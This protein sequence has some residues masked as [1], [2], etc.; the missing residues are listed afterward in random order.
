MRNSLLL[1]RMRPILITS[2]TEKKVLI[3]SFSIL[4]FMVCDTFLFPKVMKQEIVDRKIEHEY[5]GR[6]RRGGRARMSR[7]EIVTNNRSFEVYGDL[8]G[9][10][11]NND[12]ILVKISMITRSL[13]S[14]SVKRESYKEYKNGYITT[15]KGSVLVP[16]LLATVIPS[17]LLFKR[18]P[19]RT[20]RRGLIIILTVLTLVQF[21][22]Y[23]IN[24][25]HY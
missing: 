6:S 1:F 19:S 13:I 11:R 20:G 8:Y 9:K 4:V 10:I 25:R 5:E 24:S 7:Y 21:Y 2:N 15:F 12:T 18:F 23:I 14:V 16:L 22:F 3:V 17:L